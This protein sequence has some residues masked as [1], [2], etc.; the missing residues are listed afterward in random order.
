MV[1]N[2][3]LDPNAGAKGRCA[4]QATRA[5]VLPAHRRRQRHIR[6]VTQKNVA[7]AD[8]GS[9]CS[10]WLSSG[11]LYRCCNGA[12]RVSRPFRS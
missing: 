7:V 8:P 1:G 11:V 12:V 9:P 10:L 2:R 3:L 6:P 4:E 5:R